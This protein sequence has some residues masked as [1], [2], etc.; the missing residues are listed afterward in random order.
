MFADG[1]LYAW[2]D[3]LRKQ[4]IGEK[5]RCHFGSDES[6]VAAVKSLAFLPYIVKGYCGPDSWKIA[7]F[8][9]LNCIGN[10][11]HTYQ[12][13]VVVRCIFTPLAGHRFAGKL[14]KP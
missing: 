4:R 9:D 5:F 11:H 1:L 8:V 14:K 6:M 2:D 13:I 7:A 3:L 10:R 12:V